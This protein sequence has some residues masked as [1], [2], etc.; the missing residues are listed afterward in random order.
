MH[1]DGV[2]FVLV[3]VCQIDR[4]RTH[5]FSSSR[6]EFRV[7]P[8]R[9]LSRLDFVFE[10][11]VRLEVRRAVRAAAFR[12][13][14]SYSLDTNNEQLRGRT[15][16]SRHQRTD[17]TGKGPPPPQQPMAMAMADH[18]RPQQATAGHSKPYG[19][20]VPYLAYLSAQSSTTTR[21]ATFSRSRS[22]S[23]TSASRFSTARP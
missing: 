17:R 19:N 22:R 20:N 23:S 9:S 14:I 13:R 18:S 4:G 12:L 7:P 10:S 8:V 15:R 6:L 2:C 21:Q 11:I 3:F 1:D 5:I 16:G